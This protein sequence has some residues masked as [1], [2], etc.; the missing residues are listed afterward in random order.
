[1]IPTGKSSFL[2]CCKVM[3]DKGLC[4][5][6]D[7]LDDL[8]LPWR[9]ISRKL[10][11]LFWVKSSVLATIM[12]NTVTAV[13]I[14]MTLG[15]CN[16]VPECPAPPGCPPTAA[17]PVQPPPTSY[18]NPIFIP[19]AD[20]QCAWEQTVDMVDNYFRI[21]HEEPVRVFG[22][23]VTEGA[24]TT[25][26]EISPTIFE[27]WRHD[28]VDSDQRLENT[29]QTMRRRAVVRVI[30]AQ[31]GHLVD[32]QVYKELE[33]NRRPE[34][35]MA[36]AATLRYDDTLNRVIDP[37]GVQVITKGWIGQGRDTSLEQYMIGDL[38]SRCGQ[39]GSPT[40]VRG[41]NAAK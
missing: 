2:R 41:Q 5:A 40:V 10:P 39:Y 21:E 36:G 1:L 12:R 31:G 3:L 20:P 27:P 4:W 22:N 18:N 29:L 33:D 16:T 25:M 17:A 38:L 26:A 23:T 6:V 15:G 19:V 7:V 9:V 8:L 37:I 11:P 34:H 35:S 13:L 14:A 30:P 28:T 32:V 24:I